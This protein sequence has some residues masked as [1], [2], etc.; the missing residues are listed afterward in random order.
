MCW[1]RV[2]VWWTHKHKDTQTHIKKTYSLSI[3]SGV[4]SGWGM[5]HLCKRCLYIWHWWKETFI[6]EVCNILWKDAY[7]Y[8]TCF[9]HLRKETFMYGK[10]I[11]D[12][13]WSNRPTHNLRNWMFA[14]VPESYKDIY[15]H[16]YI[17][18]YIHTH[19]HIH[20]FRNKCT[21]IYTY[22]YVHRC[23]YIFQ[24]V[25]IIQNTL[26]LRHTSVLRSVRHSELIYLRICIHM[27]MRIYICIYIYVSETPKHSDSH[28]HLRG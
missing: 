12:K 11:V 15:I 4:R 18:I 23:I 8:H 26:T 19:T 22:V 20:T 1:F 25:N 3:T 16:T 10:Y 6:Y 21:N 7:I 27:Y 17:Y 9:I 13:D 2:S 24:H 5:A 28:A 14:S